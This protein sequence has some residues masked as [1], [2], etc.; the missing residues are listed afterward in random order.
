MAEDQEDARAPSESDNGAYQALR[1][2]ENVLEETLKLFQKEIEC[3]DSNLERQL[4]VTES[5]LEE[6][7]QTAAEKEDEEFNAEIERAMDVIEKLGLDFEAPSAAL[8]S[9]AGPLLGVGKGMGIQDIAKSISYDIHSGL[10]DELETDIGE[11]IVD[12]ITLDEDED[13]VEEGS[14]EVEEGEEEDRE[15]L[16]ERTFMASPSRSPEKS[17]IPEWV[18]TPTQRQRHPDPRRAEHE[19]PRRFMDATPRRAMDFAA[20][21]PRVDGVSPSNASS[22]HFGTDYLSK[23]SRQ[24]QRSPQYSPIWPPYG[25]GARKGRRSPENLRTPSFMKDSPERMVQYENHRTKSSSK[26]IKASY[27]RDFSSNTMDHSSRIASPSRMVG[28]SYRHAS[29]SRIPA[30]PSFFLTPKKGMEELKDILPPFTSPW[31]SANRSSTHQGR[32][33]RKSGRLSMGRK[34]GRFSIGKNGPQ[35]SNG[36]VVMS[37]SFVRTPL[38]SGR[39]LSSIIPP[40]S[41]A[42]VGFATP[43]QSLDEVYEEVCTPIIYRFRRPC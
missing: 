32:T 36:R 42:A 38:K 23:T 25:E 13:Y 16:T 19:T 3:L 10:A 34:S 29:P 41:Y 14:S 24:A 40:V 21:R 20:V 39:R 9:A 7:Y 33:P 26:R 8:A 5:A 1:Q 28:S 37:S 15:D 4:S 6:A 12:D 43:R 27:N 17:K 18:R 2:D 11:T 31:R 30:T 22:F 35:L